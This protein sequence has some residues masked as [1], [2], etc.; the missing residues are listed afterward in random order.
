MNQPH[1]EDG[2]HRGPFAPLSRGIIRL[3]T[4][5]A[6]RSRTTL[7]VGALVAG[8]AL[9]SASRIQPSGSIES[10]LAGGEASRTLARIIE[11]F[12][13]ADDLILLVSSQP[14]EGSAA[15]A[16]AARERLVA[17]AGQVEAALRD[18]PVLAAMCTDVTYAPPPQIASF[19]RDHLVPA[20]LWYLDDAGFAELRERLGAEGIREQILRNED[21]LSAPGVGGPTVTKAVLRDPLRL[22]ELLLASLA[23]RFPAL[24]PLDTN[25]LF[26]SRDGRTLMIRL[27]GARPA[28]DLDFARTFVREVARLVERIQPADLSVEYTGAYAIATTAERSIRRDM[29]GSMTGSIVLLL[30]L[31]L[32]AYRRVTGF[33]PA[34][35]PVG[36]GIVL[37]FGAGA[38]MFPRLTPAAGAIGAVLA[39]LSIDY[40]IHFLSHFAHEPRDGGDSRA[41]AER[42]LSHVGPALA[43]ACLTSVI[44]FL[45]IAQSSVPALRQFAWLG[46]IGL[47][48]A[49]LATVTLL[50]AVLCMSTRGRWGGNVMVPQS[51]IVFGAAV[52]SLVCFAT[53]NARICSGLLGVV[54]LAALVSAFSSPGEL[55]RIEHDLTV[56]HPRPNRPLELQHTLA[57]RFGFDPDALLIHLQATDTDA[58][59]RSAHDVGRALRTDD[60]RAVGLIGT[61]G[62]ASVL[63]DPAAAG[64]RRAAAQALD[65]DRIVGDFRSAIDE[66]LFDPAAFDGY[67]AFLRRFLTAEDPP[68]WSTLRGYSV[69]AR[70][71]FPRETA[72][73]APDAPSGAGPTEALMVCFS[74][75]PRIERDQ[76]DAAIE[77][78]RRA[79]RSS[80]GATLTGVGVVAHDTEYRI[81]GELARMMSLAAALVVACVLAHLRSLTRTLFAFLPAMFALTCLVEL[82]DVLDLRLNMVNLIGVPILV[83]IGVDAGLILV[84]VADSARRHR[85]RRDELAGRLIAS[86]GAVLLATL[87]TVLCFGTLSFTSTPAIRSLGMMLAVGISSVWL[88][89]TFLLVPLL[90]LR[91]PAD[92]PSSEAGALPRGSEGTQ[93]RTDATDRAMQARNG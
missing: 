83:G 57:E 80:P 18:S 44:G 27:T 48:G 87:T 92:P 52:T 69:I 50:P 73:S 54:M 60:A 37:A 16:T 88:A 29:I 22:H 86:G 35:V 15:P 39:G 89:A 61:F 85:Y 24:D 28:S 19:I 68:D 91:Y 81:T 58:L 38:W 62:P 90:W 33:L 3:G 40:S 1:V 4:L 49:F 84:S 43:A 45:A 75:R 67:A 13:V 56:M 10:M 64:E 21:L 32:L 34:M 72:R 17:F 31:F 8:A 46:V 93:P 47:T 42:A 6:R 78:V 26:L 70:L 11:R 76:R 5:A 30:L 65:V 74:D 20:G 55:V 7:V 82:A 79:L 36:F 2:L 9:L 23:D 63:P 41:A 14:T 59:I 66:S 77:V 53:R 25:P 71:M 51:G 12:G